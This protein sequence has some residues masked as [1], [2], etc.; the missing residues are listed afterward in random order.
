MEQPE[1]QHVANPTTPAWKTGALNGAGVFQAPL[2][3]SVYSP[4]AAEVTEFSFA[5]YF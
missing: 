1:L 2:L 5:F 4:Q 3:K